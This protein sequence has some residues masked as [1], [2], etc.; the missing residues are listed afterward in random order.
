[1]KVRHVVVIGAARSGTR[2][3]RDTLATAAG[4][5]VIPYDIGYVWRSGNEG[6]PD[7]VIPPEEIDARTRRF[8][9]TFVERYADGDP[10]TVIEKTV[11]NALRVPAVAEVLPDAVYI[12]LIRDGVDAIE[13]ARR[14]W[15]AKADMRY[16]VAKAQHFPWRLIPTYGLKYVRSQLRRRSSADQRVISWGP[17]YPGIDADLAS[18]DLLTVCARQWKCAVQMAT[19]DLSRL[20]VP[21][22]NIRYEDLVAHPAAQLSAVID[23]AGLTP[24]G[25]LKSAAAVIGVDR[26]GCGRRSLTSSELTV[27]DGEVGALLSD[28]GY[29]RPVPP[30]TLGR[31]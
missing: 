19:A 16:L 10:A 2:M 20:G 31:K 12:H 8:I 14:Q 26:R 5:G 1:M 29:E 3:L 9:R 18:G 6:A 23:Q 28:L 30:R 27:L 17:R 7:D 13:S 25:D 22:V 21:V 11:G 24:T 4:A 15:T